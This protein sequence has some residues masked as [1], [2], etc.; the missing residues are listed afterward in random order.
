MKNLII[1]L[2]AFFLVKN[3]SFAQLHGKAK[4]DSL[5]NELPKMKEDTNGVNLLSNI[6]VSYTE[7]NPE[8]GLNYIQR[9][10]NLSKKIG[11]QRGFAKLYLNLGNIYLFGLFDNQK[12]M[13]HFEKSLKIFLDLKSMVEIANVY[14]KFGIIF[15]NKPDYS[16]SLEYFFKALKIYQELNNKS[17]IAGNFGN[18]GIIYQEQS[19]FTKSLMYYHKSLKISE[20]LNDKEAIATMFVNMGNL[21]FLQFDYRQAL[22]YYEKALKIEQE[23]DDKEGIATNLL[24]IGSTYFGID[25]FDN[26]MKYFE[27]A[28]KI[29]TE[30]A[31]KDGLA[32]TFLNIG[33]VYEKKKDFNNAIKYFI[34]SLEINYELGFESGIAF[35][36][37]NIGVHYLIMAN[38]IENKNQKESKLSESIEYLSSALEIFDRIGETYSKA[39][40]LRYLSEAYE[41]K[42]DY[43]KAITIFKEYKF[44]QDSIFT[45][46]KQKEVANLEAK[47]ENEIKD[48]RINILEIQK[49][50]QQLQSYILIV[51][52]VVLFGAFGIAFIRFRE[53]KKLSDKLAFQ[54]TEIEKQKNLVENQKNIVEEQKEI[55][56]EKNEQIYSSI[57]YA[58]TIQ[59]AILPWDSIIKTAFPDIL[60]FY[61]PKDIVSGDSY[62]FQEVDGIKYLAVID[63]TGHG[64][65]GAMLTVIASTA[66]D[67]A[68]LG[69]KLSDTGQILTYMNEKV[70]E[71][72][73]QKLAENKIRDGMEV[74][75]IAF[76]KDKIQFSGAGRPL[77]LKN[78]TMEIIKT[79]KRGI[80]GQTENDEYEFSSVEVEKNEK[81]MLY[82]SSDGFA[83][84]MNENSK[85]FSTKRFTNLLES[86]SEKPL[87]E[88]SIILENEF[89]SHRGNREQIDDITVLGVRV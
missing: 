10:L 4:I 12:A 72:L 16:K 47:R 69:K 1:L 6:A 38:Q 2:I 14:E 28:L 54:N 3:I 78:G 32:Q 86:I 65:P 88:Q 31:Y 63:C 58:A 81:L 62:W 49:T 46:E 25:D 80:A 40:F 59:H 71:V 67:D 34:K 5:L 68:V 45:I 11:W 75:L 33:S 51:G 35:S 77:Y 19:D 9:G 83:D 26:A 70:T 60:I 24:N 76:Q 66:L 55:L 21:Y 73:N 20:E 57:N 36:K 64:I 43:K 85:K 8:E 79:D 41:I 82:L 30:M 17:Q 37:A 61:K 50:N 56:Q 48:A 13:E 74:G 22:K 89:N 52:V 15:G 42:G 29:N 18:I 23:L 87:A 39:N 53:K 44:L 7:I 84:Q 27:M